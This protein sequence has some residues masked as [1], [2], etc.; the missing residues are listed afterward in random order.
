MK[1]NEKMV[2]L[3]REKG[4]NQESLAFA[5]HIQLQYLVSLESGKVDH[6]HPYIINALAHV[7]DVSSMF[8]LDES[9]EAHY[10]Y[11]TVRQLERLYILRNGVEVSQDDL[12]KVKV[13][14]RK[15]YLKTL[16]ISFVVGLLIFLASLLASLL[17]KPHSQSG[18]LTLLILGIIV[19]TLI[20]IFDVFLLV[21]LSPKGN[22]LSALLLE[23]F[24]SQRMMEEGIVFNPSL[25]HVEEITIQEG[26]GL[27][28]LQDKDGPVNLY[29]KREEDLF[30]NTASG[31]TYRKEKEIAPLDQPLLVEDYPQFDISQEARDE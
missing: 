1:L 11:V 30:L 10:T 23:T 20:L 13:V 19:F 18:F 5:M 14:S 31:V 8:L 2:I 7:L 12:D 25:H 4:L 28:R 21:S 6:P 24:Y 26:S 15:R 29:T 9:Q 3:R 16:I 17:L 22:K 27:W